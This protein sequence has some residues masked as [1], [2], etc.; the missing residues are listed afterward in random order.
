MQA[1]AT[2]FKLVQLQYSAPIYMLLQLSWQSVGLKSPAS[3]VQFQP[4]APYICPVSSVGIRACGFYP[5]SREFESLTGCQKISKKESDKMKIVN[6]GNSFKIYDN[7]LKTFESLPIQSYIVRY[8]KM[9]GFF[10]ETYPNIEITEKIYGVHKEK[11]AK[12]MKSFEIFDRNLGVILSGE[13]GIGKSICAKLL[14]ED[15]VAKGYP[16]IVVNQYIP[17]IADYIASIEQKVVVLFDEF[18]KTFFSGDRD[19]IGDP[20]T[21]MLTLFDGLS[22]GKKLFVVTCN[23]LKNLNN[24]LV[25]RPGRFHYHFR[26]DY[27]TDNEVREYLTDKLGAAATAEIEKVVSFSHKVNLN[28]DCLRSIAFELSIGNSFED[29]I[30]DLNIMNIQREEY[31]IVVM[32]KG[33]T[34][35]RMIKDYRMDL[36]EDEDINIRMNDEDGFD[37]NVR[38]NPTDAVYKYELGGNIIRGEDI[39]HIDWC[40]WYYDDDE[41]DIAKLNERK[42]REIDY[43]LIRRN[44]EKNIHYAV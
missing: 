42:K 1:A 16:L 27:P 44:Y 38:F 37:F 40:D 12:V 14:A 32:F 20:Q 30:A 2:R 35:S 5:Q 22:M 28:Y 8:D 18:D 19:S 43:I 29:A 41:E 10:L 25:N 11:V 33:G 34:R 13:K 24:Y 15:A 36:F 31:N 9:S 3:L 23:E 39:N 6:T 17:G 7:S 26:F 21:E 4:E